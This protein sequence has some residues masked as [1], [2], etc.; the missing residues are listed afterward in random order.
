MYSNRIIDSTPPFPPRPISRTWLTSYSTELALKPGIVASSTYIPLLPRYIAHIPLD[1]QTTHG[2]IARISI[3][4]FIIP[5]EQYQRQWQQ[6]Q[7]PKRQWEKTETN[8]SSTCPPARCAH[9]GS[10]EC[11]SSNVG[12]GNTTRETN[13]EIPRSIRIIPAGGQDTGAR[14]GD[15]PIID[16][17]PEID[18]PQTFDRRN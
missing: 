13:G 17:M 7:R 9:V 8:S 1:S 18:R 14:S 15:R 16:P 5:Y 10:L 12:I 4:H 2:I 3:S 6:Q 11:W